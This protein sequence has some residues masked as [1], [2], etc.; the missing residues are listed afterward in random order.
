MESLIE[1]LS[2]SS[3]DLE[4]PE[5]RAYLRAKTAESEVIRNASKRQSDLVFAKQL[6]DVVAE[7]GVKKM[8]RKSKKLIDA[9]VAD[10]DCK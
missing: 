4:S 1:A 5:K 8:E 9:L 7:T 3:R 2:R 10:V 6:L